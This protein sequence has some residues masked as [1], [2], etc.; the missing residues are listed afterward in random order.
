M[1]ESALSPDSVPIRFD[2]D[3][4][5]EP[6]LV[7]VHGWSCDRTYWAAQMQA[8]APRHRV[9]A[10]DL[11][12]HGES[13]TGR[14]SWTMPAFGADVVAVADHLGL[15]DIVLIGHSMGGD[16]IVEAALLLGKR[17]RGLVCVDVYATL[18]E[19]R[20]PDEVSAFVDVVRR[21]FASE[22]GKFVREMFASGT[23]PELVER[24]VADMSAA[25][26]DIAIDALEHAFSNEG[27]FTAGIAALDVPVVSI[28]A[29]YEPTDEGALGRH[30]LMPV[31]MS[32]ASHFLM[33]E[34]P[35]RFNALL[36]DAV[37]AIVDSRLRRSSIE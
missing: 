12:G 1:T 14:S 2:V 29:D 36:E 34:A 20:S 28:T 24:V 11:A 37:A 6:T 7:F 13:G 23:D 8:F 5:A 18:G 33:M 15:T 26:P 35:D 10:V 31:I 32:D 22:T 3:G 16:V 4:S 25:P 17:V 19:P 30:G 21:D 9:V 27:P